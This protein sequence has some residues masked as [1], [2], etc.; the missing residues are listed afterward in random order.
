MMD[1]STTYLGLNLRNPIIVGSSGMTHK[2]TDLIAL[3]KHGAG[4]VVLKS[5]FEEEIVLELEHT[6]NQMSSQGFIYPETMEYF[7]YE[8]IEDTLSS[9]LKLIRD[10]KA[11]LSIPVI[12]SI[13]CVTSQKWTHFAKEIEE[14]GAD[15]LE[16]NAF[17]LPSDFSRVEGEFEKV[18]FEIVEE[19]KKQISIPI[20]LKVS[21]FFSNLG[22]MLQRLSETGTEG[23]VLF[24]RFYSPDFDVDKMQVTAS[25]VLSTPQE[26]STSLRWIAI[27]SERSACDLAASTGVHDGKGVVKQLLAGAK[28]VQVASALYLHGPEHISVMLR[29][30]EDWMETQ[31][32]HSI[33]NF[34]GKM[35]QAK[36]KNPAAY[37]RVQFMKYFRDRE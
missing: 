2:L 17:I 32:Y 21:Y 9:Y 37:E 23:L 11:Q 15:A 20:S 30:M 5:I 19:V 35:S 4:A 16:L 18:Y 12:A 28:A 22:P 14:A 13:N 8:E 3:E 1:L 10:A 33:D 34:R 24:N 36:S 27:L 26:I 6:F 29:E 7:D 25:N 31:G